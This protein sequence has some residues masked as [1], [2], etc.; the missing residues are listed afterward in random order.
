MKKLSFKETIFVA[1]MLFGMFFGAGNLIFPVSMGQM[2]GDHIWL[3]ALGFLVTGVGLPLLGVAALGISR[4]TGLLGLA[5]RIGKNYGV[6]FTCA[7]YLTIGPFFAIPRCASVSYTVGIERILEGQDQTLWLAV[8]SFLF[9]AIVLFFSLRPGETMAPAEGYKSG[10]L[11][12]GFLEGYNT[13]DALAALAFG[14]V[15]IEVIRGLGVEQPGQIAKDTVK[16]GIFSSILMAVIYVLVT[17]VGGQSRGEFGISSNGGEGLALI[18][19]HYFGGAG[20]F[21]LALMVTLACLKTAIG[22]ITSCSETFSEMFPKSPG[23]RFWA[24][25][26]SVVSF[27]I[28]NL[29]L[30]AIVAY[31]VPVLMF[32]YPLAIV[33]VLLTLFGNW[34]D[35]NRHVL[36]WTIAFTAVAAL[37]DFLRALP[38]G[39]QD[40]LHTAPVTDMLGNVIPLSEL[41]FG[42]IVPA[43]VGFVIG[44]IASRRRGA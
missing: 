20:M 36:R 24:V 40:A 12:T 35:N 31:S 25:L 44:L 23:Y 18:A 29:G 22:L 13:M 16:A 27:L 28:A 17:L 41:G 34:F 15:V 21:I 19:D 1:S 7:L 39:T 8:F 37:A 3:A 33:L 11:F 38:E 43:A 5:S 26:F 14:I 42:W 4:E 32:L 10:A 9:F 2:A 30:N 6:F